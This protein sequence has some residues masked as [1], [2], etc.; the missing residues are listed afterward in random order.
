MPVV[1]SSWKV[2]R[3]LQANEQLDFS[4]P[5]WTRK[6]GEDLCAAF[7]AKIRNRDVEPDK[8][9]P[10]GGEVSCLRLWKYW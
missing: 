9:Y 5:R 4:R 1:M 7:V 6:R 3:R 2:N 8:C 10:V